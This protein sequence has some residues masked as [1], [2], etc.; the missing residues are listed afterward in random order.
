MHVYRLIWRQTL[1]FLHNLIV[2]VVMLLVFPQSLTLASLTAVPAFL[3]LML[4]GAW[5][6]LFVG[7]VTT[8]FRDIMPIT[9]SV[10]QL[11][12]FLTPVVWIYDELLNSPNPQI[13][14]R[15]II[16]RQRPV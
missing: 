9:Q 16:S 4:N 6:A 8:R 3:L 12:F 7:I 2:Y 11:M 13:A 10:V 15:L 1:F 14:E 5:V